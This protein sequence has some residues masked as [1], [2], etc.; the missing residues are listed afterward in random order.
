M[1]IIVYLTFLSFSVGLLGATDGIAASRGITVVSKKG[2]SLGIYK[3]YQALVV[4]V[5]NYRWWPNLPNAVQDARDVGEMLK[6][7]GFEV[8]LVAAI[9]ACG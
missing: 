7:L 3:D 2:Q 4:G 6:K 8:K 9:P 5:G 1:K